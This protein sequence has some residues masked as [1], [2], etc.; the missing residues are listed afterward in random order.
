[1]RVG[2]KSAIAGA[3]ALLLTNGAAA[4][5][6]NE[7]DWVSSARNL[8][9]PWEENSRT[10][11]NGAIRIAL[12]DT[13]EP[14]CCSY[15]L[16]VLSPHPEWGQACHVISEQPGQGWVEIKF[17]KQKAKYDPAKGL[18]VNIRVEYY[19]PDTGGADPDL[20]HRVGIRINQ[21]TGEVTLE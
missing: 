5:S 3:L 10:F 13:A 4:Q 17:K 8:V 9:E 11:A 1:M 14:A 18:R 21:A 2:L 20:G 16:L 6:V 19:D 15:H 7:C 12:L